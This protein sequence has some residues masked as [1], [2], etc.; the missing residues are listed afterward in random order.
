MRNIILVVSVLGAV[1]SLAAGITFQKKSEQSSG[2]E[3]AVQKTQ[4]MHLFLL[5]G[6]FVLFGMIAYFEPVPPSLPSLYNPFQKKPEPNGL[7]RYGLK[8]GRAHV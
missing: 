4:A 6:V 8:I 7:P 1:A 3:S 2:E 5:S